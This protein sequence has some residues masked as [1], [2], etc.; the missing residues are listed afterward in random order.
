MY[1]GYDLFL[2]FSDYPCTIYNLREIDTRTF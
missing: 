2:D 1:S